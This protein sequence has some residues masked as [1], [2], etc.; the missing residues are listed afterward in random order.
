[1]L[2]ASCAKKSLP[3]LESD[4]LDLSEEQTSVLPVT[5]DSLSFASGTNLWVVRGSFV[6]DGNEFPFLSVYAKNPK[7]RNVVPIKVDPPACLDQ[8]EGIIVTKFILL[9]ANAISLS[10]RTEEQF[11]LIRTVLTSEH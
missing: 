8:H 1:M 5:L 9:D 2:L 11:L 3:F 4:G 10:W 6:N 7:L